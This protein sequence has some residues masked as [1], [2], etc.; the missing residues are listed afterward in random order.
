MD[1]V[2]LPV[3]AKKEHHINRFRLANLAI[4]RAKELMEGNA[5]VINTKYTKETTIALGEIVSADFVLLTGKEAREAMRDVFKERDAERG[6][7][8]EEDE[9]ASEIKNDLSVYLND[10]SKAKGETE[11][12]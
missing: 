11:E 1:I 8:E 3:E 7:T 12:E 6:I 4:Q 5:P 9:E 10:S 2:S